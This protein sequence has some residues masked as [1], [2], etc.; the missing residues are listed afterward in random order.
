MDFVPDLTANLQN[1][2]F[3][4]PSKIPS[5]ALPQKTLIPDTMHICRLCM[6]AC[7]CVYIYQCWAV[8]KNGT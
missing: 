6:R 4:S 2:H 3:K 1:A 7:V 8:I 5:N